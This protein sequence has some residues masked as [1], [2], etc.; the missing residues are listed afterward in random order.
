MFKQI[1][2]KSHKFLSYLTLGLGLLILSGNSLAQRN[3]TL[4]DEDKLAEQVFQVLASEIALQRGEIALAYQTYMSLAKNS[5]DPQ[6]AQRAMEIAIA[7]KSP[8][9][10]L[11]AARLWDELAGPKSTTSREVLITLLMLN[12][13]WEESVEP[14][15]NYLSKLK[16]ADREKFL[17]QWQSLISRSTNDDQ[18]VRAFTQIIGAFKP[19]PN[20]PELLFIYALGQEKDKNYPEMEAALKLIIKKNPNDKN[21]LNALGYSYAD[22]NIKLQEAYGLISKAYQLSPGDAYILDS[23]AWVNFRLG[24]TQLAASQLSKAF[25]MKPEAEMGAHLG[26]ILWTLGDKAEADK[27]WKKA[28]EINAN[29]PTLKDTL[30]RLRAE[31]ALPEK[32]DESINRRWDGRFAVKIN[33]KTSQDGGSGAFTLDHEP[34]NDTLEIRGPL[35]TSIAKVN[36]GP[37]EAILE[38]N[39]VKTE[40]IDADTLVEKALGLPLPARGLSAWLAGYI[41]AGSPGTVERDKNGQVR[42]ILQDGWVLNYTWSKKGKIEKLSMTRQSDMAD[43]DIRLIFDNVDE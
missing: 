11:E 17:L 9:S 37:S 28:E 4:Q 36:V 20:S 8:G 25:E 16:P 19:L 2:S 29:D 15:I 12:G 23:L 14:S 35:G 42:K 26:E 40:A 6:M 30:R 24:N 21:A 41:R 3:L 18:G 5:K 39:G 34:L 38:Q 22:R 27:V 33:G 7:G 1:V 10:S 13:K 43:V 31:W 32:F